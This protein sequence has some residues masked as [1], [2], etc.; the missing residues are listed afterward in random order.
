MKEQK[1]S[2]RAELRFGLKHVDGHEGG[3]LEA[4][5]ISWKGHLPTL[6]VGA[7]APPSGPPC[8]DKLDKANLKAGMQ[9]F[10]DF[11]KRSPS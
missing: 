5:A 11:Q 7:L 2:V 9:P 3:G 6:S 10:N 4:A 8:P 1:E